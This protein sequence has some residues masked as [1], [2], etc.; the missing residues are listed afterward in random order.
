LRSSLEGR[1]F[2]VFAVIDQREACPVRPSRHAS[3]HVD[4]LRKSHRRHAADDRGSDF[5]IELPL[6]VLIREDAERKVF[7]V[8]SPASLLEGRHG[9]PAG[10]A[11]RLG[12]AEPHIAEAVG[13]RS[14]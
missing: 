13:M 8:Y 7:V 5:A 3:D 1:G 9:L 12:G 10:L 4:R 6:K 2:T 11:A 14:D